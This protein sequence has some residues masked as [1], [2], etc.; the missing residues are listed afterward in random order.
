M[1][2]YF[3]TLI[4][5]VHEKCL[6]SLEKLLKDWELK[7]IQTEN[8]VVNVIN[9]IKERY[10]VWT[11]D[12]IVKLFLMIQY[13]IKVRKALLKILRQVLIKEQLIKW[14]KKL[15]FFPQAHDYISRSDDVSQYPEINS[16][17]K[18]KKRLDELLADYNVSQYLE[19]NDSPTA[20]DTQ[21]TISDS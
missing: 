21:S 9:E 16:A 18:I 20:S 17:L 4:E 6:Y 12:H 2:R 8:G 11:I 15:L 19:L 10:S 14:L 1:S 3:A 13:L 7:E 5:S